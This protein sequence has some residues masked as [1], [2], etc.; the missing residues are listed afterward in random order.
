MI[1]PIVQNKT[2]NVGGINTQLF[3][4]DFDISASDTNSLKFLT[5]QEPP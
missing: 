5:P 1:K 3:H 2:Q 4:E